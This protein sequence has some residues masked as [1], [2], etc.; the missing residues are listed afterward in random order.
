MEAF[1]FYFVSLVS[2][3]QQNKLY[4]QFAC[5]LCIRFYVLPGKSFHQ[6]LFR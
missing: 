2:P 3:Q 6:Q 5:I 1:Q 4:H